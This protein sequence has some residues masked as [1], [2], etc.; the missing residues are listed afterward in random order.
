MKHSV[1]YIIAA[2]LVFGTLTFAGTTGTITG[3]VIDGTT[4]QPVPG[5]VVE[6]CG[7]SMAV[8]TDINGQYTIVDV[9]VGVYTLQARM[10]GYPSK[11]TYNVH[12]TNDSI[13]KVKVIKMGVNDNQPVKTLLL[14]ANQ[15]KLTHITP[16]LNTDIAINTNLIYCATFQ[17][18]WNSLQDNFFKEPLLLTGNP[19]DAEQLNKQAVTGTDLDSNSYVAIA[20]ILNKALLQRINTE[21]KRKFGVNAPSIIVDEPINERVLSILSYCYLYKNLV[22]KN[23]FHKNDDPLPF[24][25]AGKKSLVPSFG[26]ANSVYHNDQAELA[27]QVELL[28]FSDNDNFAIR[29]KTTSTK[30]ELILAKIKPQKNLLSTITAVNSNITSRN[31]VLM[32]DKER[33]MIPYLD[34]D[35]EHSFEQ[36]SHKPFLNNGWTEWMISKAIQK[37]RFKLNESGALLKSEARIVMRGT[38]QMEVVKRDYI[39]D[40]PFLIMLRKKGSKLPYFAMWVGNTELLGKY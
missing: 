5:A 32:S 7:S 29:L 9:P 28:Y 19:W 8:N 3:R 26:I 12:S 1:L 39:F 36:L 2:L 14:T 18:A 22:F 23:K 15:L 21:L 16:H 30:D 11:K 24:F 37:I 27:K 35:I 25:V 33:L 10:M 40:K 4:N 38:V 6:I 34:F 31:I 17:I 13:T 20:D